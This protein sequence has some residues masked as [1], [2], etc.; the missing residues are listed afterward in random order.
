MDYKRI[1]RSREVRMCILNF[2]QFVPD[3]WMVR[4]QYR[5]K[6]GRKLNLQNPERYTEK[7][8]WYKLHYRNELM[9]LCVNKF[10]VRDYVKACGMQDIL[11]ELYGVYDCPEDIPFDKLPNQFVLKDTLGGGSTSVI[12]VKDKSKLDMAQTVATMKKWVSRNMEIN[13]GGREWP[14]MHQTPQI[15]AEKYLEQE[16]GDLADYKLFCFYGN[17]RYIYVRDGYAKDHDKGQM[18]FFDRDLNYLRGVGMDYCTTAPEKP[19]ID[20]GI[21]HKMIDIAERLS[22]QFPHVRVDLYEVNKQI[23]FGELTF[24]NASGYMKFE[25][26]EFDYELGNAFSLP[27]GGTEKV[28]RLGSAYSSDWRCAA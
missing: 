11:N 25:P 15:I 24:F 28:I 13:T 22:A 4:L 21:L 12:V 7:L 23:I 9:P 18:A 5:I 20:E 27:G 26:D 2:L 3:Q 14:Y 17:V 8:Q 16:N 6:T 10:K 1:I 19:Q